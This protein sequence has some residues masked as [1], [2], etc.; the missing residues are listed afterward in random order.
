MAHPIDPSHL[1]SNLG[2]LGDEAT[3]SNLEVLGSLPPD[4]SGRLLGIGSHF[5]AGSSGTGHGLVHSVHLHAGRA[6]SYRSRWVRT[7]PIAR[8]LGIEPVPGP[9]SPTGSDVVADGILV[10][11]DAIL[12][13]GIGSLAY[14]LSPDLET[15]RRVDLAGQ[16]RGLSST[17]KSDPATGDLHLIASGTDGGQ[18][19]VVVSSGALT[20]RS[21]PILVQ[22]NQ[23]SDLAITRHRI[24]LVANGFIG[25]TSHD[26][27]PPVTWFDSKVDDALLIGAHDD[28]ETVLALTIT[29][30]LEQ[31]TL[32]VPSATLH[33]EILDPTPRHSAFTIG[34][35][36]HEA[37][38]HLWAIGHETVD[39]YDLG[40]RSHAQHRFGSRNPGELAF[41]ADATRARDTDGGW[42]IGFVHD[43]SGAEAVLVVLDAAD[44]SKLPI[45]TIRLPRRIPRRLHSTWVPSAR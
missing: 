6:L 43:P 10:F 11:G 3:V 7:G 36:G 8:R 33:R 45:A 38:Q 29:P 18:A 44:T 25:V 42:L 22:P 5:V 2:E 16:T 27:E 32:H 28:G 40:A 24:V 39:K 35:T 14:E 15:L 19:H 37:P 12:A 4:L 17:P 41:V 30:S 26:A 23:V 1:A 13:F 20:R 34:R 21:R 31:W 9:T